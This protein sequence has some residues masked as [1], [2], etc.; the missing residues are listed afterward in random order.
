M[1][2]FSLPPLSRMRIMSGTTTFYIRPFISALRERVGE[3]HQRGRKLF[4]GACGTSPP[5][6]LLRKE[7]GA[8]FCNPKLCWLFMLL[9]KLVSRLAFTLFPTY[10]LIKFLK[11][12]EVTYASCFAVGKIHCISPLQ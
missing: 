5:A 2:R 10:K 6:P 12:A 1:T 3:E 11:E 7:R 4:P 9:G 8:V